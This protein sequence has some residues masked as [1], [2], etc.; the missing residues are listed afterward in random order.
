M[1]RIKLEIDESMD[2]DEIFFEFIVNDEEI[3][4]KEFDTSEE[5]KEYILKFAGEQEWKSRD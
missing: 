5:F 4:N 1:T 2:K 3:E